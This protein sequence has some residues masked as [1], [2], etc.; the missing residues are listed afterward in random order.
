ME[1]FQLSLDSLNS[2]VDDKE[3]DIDTLQSEK[4]QIKGQLTNLDND[5]T[6]QAKKI[7]QLEV[8][9]LM[10]KAK[11]FTFVSVLRSRS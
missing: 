6:S 8:F 9:L 3:K 2:E 1:K 11:T 4:K 5:V 7:K 10:F